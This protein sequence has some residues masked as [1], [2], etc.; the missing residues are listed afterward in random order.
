MDTSVWIF[1]ILLDIF[2]VYTIFAI[3]FYIL[4]KYF[5]HSFEENGIVALFKTH[6]EFYKPIIK[7][8][9]DSTYNRADP[10]SI[11][12][13]IIRELNNAK[14]EYSNTDYSTTDLLVS[15][16]IAGMGLIVFVYFIINKRKILEQINLNHVLATIMLNIVFII[17]FE[18]LFI[19]FV[20]GNTDLINIAKILKLD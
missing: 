10:N 6:L 1:N 5:L 16:S 11:S 3:Y 13:E 20:Y 2:I 18:C 14:S 7:L 17:G 9:K 19:F 8:F 4:V 12:A 15:V